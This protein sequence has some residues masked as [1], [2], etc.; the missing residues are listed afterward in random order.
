MTSTALAAPD[1]DEPT[2]PPPAPVPVPVRELGVADV[3]NA[4]DWWASLLEER[5]PELRWPKAYDIYDEMMDN[6]QVSSV[7]RA[8]MMPILGT[9]WRID[10]TD[11]EPHIT[12]H[13]ANDL[14]LPIVG[15][16]APETG[17]TPLEERFSWGEHAEVALEDTVRYGHGFFEQ[18]AEMG[19]D[20][21]WHLAKLG[22]RPPRSI[23][24]INTA[25]DG[26]L[27][28]IEQQ[29]AAGTVRSDGAGNKVLG[30]G[31]IVVYTRGR[32]GANWRGRS[33]L[34]PAYQPWLLNNR[35]VRIEMILAERIGAPVF[36]YEAA[37]GE[38]DL[39]AGRKIATDVR[40][41]RQAGAAIAHGAKL[42]AQ[43][44]EGQLPD[45][46]KIKRYNDEQIARAVLAHFLN[47]GTQTGSWALGSTFADFFTLSLK[48]VAQEMART[49]SRHVI[50][51]LVAW[52]WPGARA[53]RLVFD[54]IGARQEAIVQAIAVLVGAGVLKPDE[55]LEQFTRTALGLPPRAKNIKPT[56]EAS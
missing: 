16:E 22:Y 6:P 33:L 41:G 50:R 55:D 39:A 42:T 44:V 14:A 31:R 52:N 51:D 49:A 30:V 9:G 36:V 18:K 24:K 38:A 19:A 25:R 28:S 1:P 56:S 32:R 12:R 2:P 5:V 47:L 29:A 54:E 20:G 48:A 11:C 43:G 15:E 26:G 45:V 35:A 37:E 34:R 21:L 10:G 46:D 17:D 23:V 53:P 27:I 4:G 7:M 8:V 3:Q 13:V 40:A